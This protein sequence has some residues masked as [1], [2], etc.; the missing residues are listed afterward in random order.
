MNTGVTHR[1]FLVILMATGL[2]VISSVLIMH[3]SLGR[4]FLKYV[5]AMEKSGI[6][7][8]AVTLEGTYSKDK[9]WAAI[10]HDP[11]RWR[12]LIA[13]SLPETDL[14]PGET[15]QTSPPAEQAEATATSHC[16]RAWCGILTNACF[17]WMLTE[18]Y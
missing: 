4:G 11:E 9:N 12:H 3:W 18:R 8:L 7:R 14:P 5:N 13:V 2:A 6:S 15:S 10:R 1:L 17:C 16:P